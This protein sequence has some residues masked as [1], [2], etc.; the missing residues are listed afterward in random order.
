MSSSFLLIFPRAR[1]MSF[2]A[3]SSRQRCDPSPPRI[4]AL[5]DPTRCI[6]SILKET[7]LLSLA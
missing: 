1:L 7:T 4:W 6:G 5:M 2:L 3:N